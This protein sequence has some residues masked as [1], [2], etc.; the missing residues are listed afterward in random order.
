MGMMH[1][2]CWRR[3]HFCFFG[4]SHMRHVYDSFVAV[5]EGGGRDDDFWLRDKGTDRWVVHAQRSSYF[6]DTWGNPGNMSACTDVFVNFGQAS[7]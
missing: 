7:A 3:R 6:L 4:D 1:A 2:R 5:T